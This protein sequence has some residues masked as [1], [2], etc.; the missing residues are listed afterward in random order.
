MRAKQLDELAAATSTAVRQE[1]LRVDHYAA[2]D[3]VHTAQGS[4]YEANA[5]TAR[6]DPEF[7]EKYLAFI[8][9]EVIHH[10]EKFPRHP[11]A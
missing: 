2:S 7:A 8:I 9:R 10:H 3:T 5:E 1:T 11:P 4:L 6:L